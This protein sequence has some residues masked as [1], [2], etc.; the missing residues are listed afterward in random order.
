MDRKIFGWETQLELS[1]DRRVALASGGE[2]IMGWTN[3]D[4]ARLWEGRMNEGCPAKGVILLECLE[5]R[6]NTRGS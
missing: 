6:I 5:T 2:G 4:G 3:H 1:M